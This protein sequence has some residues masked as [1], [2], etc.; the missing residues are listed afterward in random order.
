MGLPFLTGVKLV[1]SALQLG[2][3]APQ[4]FK[5]LK[6]DVTRGPSGQSTSRSGLEIESIADRILS[7]AQQVT[8]TDSPTSARKALEKDPT[9]QR[10]FQKR[11]MDFEKRMA[12]ISY[13][14]R[15]DARTRDIAM[16]H[17]GRMN[18]RADIMVIAAA[19][20]LILCLASLS[21]YG[22]GL[23]GEAVGIISTIAG[24]FGACLKDAYGFEFG[25]SRGS[26]EKDSTVALL[27][28]RYEY[29]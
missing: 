27:L 17:A 7:I 18:I 3:Y 13:Q 23:P 8:A 10:A 29:D 1:Q 4:I 14:D 11:V 21:L 28:D 16:A 12:E 24:I 19:I 6:P 25:S 2:E 15:Q 9:F 26:K 22:D 5:W 20:G